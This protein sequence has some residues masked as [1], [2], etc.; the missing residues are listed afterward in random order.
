M[1]P[2]IIYYVWIGPD[3]LPT[4]YQK[5]IKHWKKIMPDYE[6]IKVDDDNILMNPLLWEA[7]SKS[8]Y[9]AMS[10]YF[11]VVRLYMTGGFYL[12]V[13]FEVIRSFDDLRKEKIILGIQATKDNEN[14]MVNNGMMASVAGHPYL[15]WCIDYLNAMGYL[16]VLES[17]VYMVTNLA[18]HLGW[19]EKNETQILG[20]LKI[21]NS[22]YFYPYYFTEEFNESCITKETHAIHHW[23]GSWLK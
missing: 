21:L 19:N 3:E 10:N 17:S 12:D 15:R 11:R 6:I 16:K 14:L 8:L 5:F 20:D 22:K 2:K 23:S 4:E 13:D 1:I 9:S 18:K 7:R